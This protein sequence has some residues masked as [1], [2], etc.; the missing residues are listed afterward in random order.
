MRFLQQVCEPNQGVDLSVVVV[1]FNTGRLLRQ[2]LRSIYDTADGLDLEIFVVDNGSSDGSVEMVQ[3]Q[4]PQVILV[5]SSDNLGFARAANLALARGR[6]S[7]FLI[8]HP[9][10]IFKTC[11]IQTMLEFLVA[12]PRV[13]IVGGNCLYPDGS[14]NDCLITRLSARLEI[15]EFAYFS[16][17]RVGAR[18]PRLVHR[19]KDWRDLSYWDHRTRTESEVIWNACMMFKREVLETVGGFC[20]EFYVW[21][22]DCDL[23]YRA[24]DA[25]WKAYY[26]PEA[27]VIHYERASGAYLDS[28]LVRYKVDAFLV[29]NLE[30]ADKHTLLRRHHSVSLLWLSKLLDTISL[31]RSLLKR[32]LLRRAPALGGRWLINSDQMVG[33]SG[34]GTMS[35]KN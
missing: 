24:V 34:R 26:L 31:W 30:N 1:N 2:C 10:V 9:D 28:Q 35:G 11:A 22:A 20:E 21:F 3:S 25:G 8:A 19:L 27:E 14:T 18:V 13:G 17:Q 32:A 29:R 7:T 33:I 15:A 16:F 12:H 23:C 6:G 5:A 4:F